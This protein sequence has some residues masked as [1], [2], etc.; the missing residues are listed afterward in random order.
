M[1]DASGVGMPAALWLDEFGAICADFFGAHVYH[2]GSSTG[3]ASE[4]NWRDVD[5]RVILTDEE[6]AELGLGDPAHPHHNRRWVALTL[7]FTA[8]GRQMTGLPID[9]QVQQQSYANEKHAGARSALGII[10]LMRRH[11]NVPHDLFTKQG[12]HE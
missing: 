7:A 9:F 2:V 12:S 11:S 5:V 6:Y 10:A 3:I 8:L 4:R 1:S